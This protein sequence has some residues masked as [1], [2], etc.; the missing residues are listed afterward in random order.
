MSLAKTIFC[1]ILMGGSVAFSFGGEA[2]SSGPTDWHRRVLRDSHVKST[3][4]VVQD[5]DPLLIEPDTSFND[6][7]LDPAPTGSRRRRRRR[8]AWR[9]RRVRRERRM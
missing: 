3:A 6:I 1:G 4:S 2:V 9:V 7:Q 8:R 5:A